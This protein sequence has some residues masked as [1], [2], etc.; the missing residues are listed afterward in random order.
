MN[1]VLGPNVSKIEQLSSFEALGGSHPVQNALSGRYRK[2]FP[3][4][5]F[6]PNPLVLL[7]YSTDWLLYICVFIMETWSLT[8]TAFDLHYLNFC[9][10]CFYHV[11]DK[12]I[13]PQ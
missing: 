2:T 6:S 8:D 4:F 1:V 13:G 12:E 3:L 7:E 9:W 10:E 5:T 11:C